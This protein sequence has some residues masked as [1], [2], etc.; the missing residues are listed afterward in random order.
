[1]DTSHQVLDFELS[2][3]FNPL[4]AWLAETFLQMYHND[5]VLTVVV[6]RDSNTTK[7]RRLVLGNRALATMKPHSYSIT[8]TKILLNLVLWTIAQWLVAAAS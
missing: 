8:P 4:R 3:H 5:F 2:D 1:M 7:A 6:G